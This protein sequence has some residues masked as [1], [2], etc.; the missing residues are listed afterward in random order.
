MRTFSI[1][2]IISVAV[3]LATGAVNTW[4]ILGTAA[5]SFGTHYNRR[6]PLSKIGVFIAMVAIA[7]VNRQLLTPRSSGRTTTGAPC[8]SCSGTASPR[9]VWA[10]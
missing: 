2:G 10:S 5:L 4:E 3:I 6:L 1:L 9:P 8:G 7:A